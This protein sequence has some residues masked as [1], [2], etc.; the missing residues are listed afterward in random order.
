MYRMLLSIIVGLFGCFLL[1]L[2]VETA[3]PLIFNIEPF[4]N[5]GGSNEMEKYIAK[6]PLNLLK[7]NTAAY[8]LSAFVGAYIANLISRDKRAGLFTTLLFFIVVLVNFFTV[9][10][11]NWMVWIGSTITLVGGLLA[12]ILQ[13]KTI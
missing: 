12:Y 2:I 3:L 7:I 1:L 13:K 5:P 11:P 8:G 9:K 10:H 6:L 4:S